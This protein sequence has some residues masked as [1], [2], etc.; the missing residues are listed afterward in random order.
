MLGLLGNKHKIFA[1]ILA[2]LIWTT[3][4]SAA[5]WDIK[6]PQWISHL[7]EGIRPQ[8]EEATE[9]AEDNRRQIACVALG[10]YYESRGESTRG[11]QAVASVIMNR[12]RSGRYPD[13]PCGVIFQRG[14]FSP[15]RGGAS[16]NPTG[17]LW[18]KAVGIAQEY[19]SKGSGDIPHLSFTAS[20]RIR[21]LR[22]G[23]H[24]FY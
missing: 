4:A 17:S 15:F 3:P 14:Q 8:S 12:V 16:K 9:Q 23:H 13:T 21:G 18:D 22:I 24:I 20:S 10:V 2:S 5:G 7:V 1:V 11:Q 19:F 6:T